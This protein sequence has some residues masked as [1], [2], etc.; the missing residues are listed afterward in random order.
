MAKVKPNGMLSGKIGNTVLRDYNGTVIASQKPDTVRNP[1]TTLQQTNRLKMRNI[2][3]MYGVMKKALKDN[4]QGKT[5]HQS[6]YSRF[7]GCNLSRPAVF[8]TFQENDGSVVAPYAVSFGTLAMIDYHLDGEWLV[9][10][11]DVEGWSPASENMIRHL[12]EC[13]V[14]NSILFSNG[15]RIEFIACYQDYINNFPMARCE[16]CEFQIRHDDST[17]LSNVLNGFELRV[18]EQNKLCF[19]KAGACGLAMVRKRGEGRDTSTSV[20]FLAV[21]NPLLANFTSEEHMQLAI[22]SYAKKK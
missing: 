12:S 7:Q 15:D 18:N 21:N 16:Y 20:Q 5:G 10:D 2:I 14:E 1:R 19:K 11:I 22:A 17:L 6:D 8:L 9:T 4:F 3:N 13:L